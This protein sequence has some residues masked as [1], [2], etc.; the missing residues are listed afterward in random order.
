MFVSYQMPKRPRTNDLFVET[1][2]PSQ[3]P[4]PVSPIS[5]TSPALVDSAFNLTQ[6]WIVTGK[7]KHK[8]IAEFLRSSKG[9]QC[10]DYILKQKLQT[11]QVTFTG[12]DSLYKAR[13]TYT[14]EPLV[15]I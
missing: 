9:K 1:S 14:R 6:L 11:N 3:Q 5:P 15:V 10:V 8:N 12:W 13:A 7:I 4:I 2:R